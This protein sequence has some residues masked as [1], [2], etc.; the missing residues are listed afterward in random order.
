MVRILFGQAGLWW[1]GG[2]EGGRGGRIFELEGVV[3]DRWPWTVVEEGGSFS[4]D[5]GIEEGGSGS[6]EVGVGNGVE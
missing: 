5:R 1:A 4:E 3:E 6:E 2:G